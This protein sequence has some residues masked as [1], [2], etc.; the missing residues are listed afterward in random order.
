MSAS[1]PER[2]GSREVRAACR[3]VFVSMSLAHV[4]TLSIFVGDIIVRCL[5]F[6]YLCHDARSRTVACP[7]PIEEHVFSTLGLIGR[8]PMVELPPTLCALA[9]SGRM[10]S[11]DTTD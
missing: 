1:G 5:N 2:K 8:T 4:S 6:L 11:G 7:I 10:E 9:L 3:R